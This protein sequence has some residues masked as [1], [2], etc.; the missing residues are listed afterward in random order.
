MHR[1]AV[2][3]RHHVSM[4]IERD[5]VVGYLES[6]FVVTVTENEILVTEIRGISYHRIY[7]PYNYQ[8]LATTYPQR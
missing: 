1:T 6:R 8:R 3:E 5:A 2:V 4:D 7:F